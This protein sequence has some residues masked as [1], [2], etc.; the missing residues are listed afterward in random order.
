MIQLLITSRAIGLM[1]GDESMHAITSDLEE[2]IDFLRLSNPVGGFSRSNYSL[3]VKL[4]VHESNKTPLD[5]INA[6]D[7]DAAARGPNI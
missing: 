1:S 5:R 2:S 7:M 6:A 4:A 3:I